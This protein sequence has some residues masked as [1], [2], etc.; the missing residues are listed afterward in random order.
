MG[1]YARR[2]LTLSPDP[3]PWPVTPRPSERSTGAYRPVCR[4][5]L[6]VATLPC[7]GGRPSRRNLQVRKSGETTEPQELAS[8]HNCFPKQFRVPTMPGV[9]RGAGGRRYLIWR[10]PPG[11]ALPL[12]GR[13]SVQLYVQPPDPV[14]GLGCCISLRSVTVF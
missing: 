11:Y 8:P 3:K 4:R 9:R 12:V 1:A 7:R 2:K 5:K 6:S 13:W 10:G 14:S